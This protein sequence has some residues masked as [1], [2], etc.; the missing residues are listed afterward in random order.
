V[1]GGEPL[2][3]AA[4]FEFML[5]ECPSCEHGRG[6]ECPFGALSL[7]TTANVAQ[8]ALYAAACFATR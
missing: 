1:I 2:T 7:F 6:R 4:M 5:G 8:L 3:T